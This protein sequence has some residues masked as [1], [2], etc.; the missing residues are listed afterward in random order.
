MATRLITAIDAAETQLFKMD[1]FILSPLGTTG[2]ACPPA[3]RE[4]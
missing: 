2:T 1:L 4:A 3:S